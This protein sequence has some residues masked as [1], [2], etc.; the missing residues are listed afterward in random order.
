MEQ[1]FI[2]I[3]C[4]LCIL[5][6]VDLYVGVSNDAV[7][8]LNSAV[9]SRIAPFKVV[10]LVAGLGVLIGAT[11]S[12]GMMEIARSGVFNPEFFTFT[13]IM[14]IFFAVMITD[15]LLLDIFN[16]LGLPT[17]TTVSIVFE[18]L[19]GAVAA[20]AYKIS[21]VPVEQLP[22]L[23]GQVI[24]SIGDYINNEKALTIISGI[25][26]SV[27]VAFFSGS[28]VQYVMRLI[29]TFKYQNVYKYLGG[30]FGGI[31]ITAIFYF[32]VMKG[33]KGSSFM[34][35][36]YIAWINEHTF[37][38]LLYS[39]ASITLLFQLL[40]SLF[41]VN[42]F[43][44][45]ILA[46]TFALAFAF[47]GNDLVNFVGVP[48]AAIDSYSNFAAEGHNMSM[49]MGS[50]RNTVQAPTIFLLF[51]GLVM[52]LTLWFSKKAQRVVRTSINLSSSSRG[53][54]EQFGSSLMARSIV[55]GVAGTGKFM[56]QIL[57]ASVFTFLEKRM[58][59]P[60][61]KKG[62]VVLPFDQVRAAIN[63]VLSSILIASATSLKLPLSTT[64]VTFM[65]AMGSSFADGAWDRESAVYRVSGVLSVIGGWFITA[66]CAFTACAGMAYLVFVG[67]KIATIALMVVVCLILVRSNFFGKKSKDSEEETSGTKS[68]TIRTTVN[69]AIQEYFTRIISVYKKGL[70]DFQGENLRQLRSDKND[71]LAIHEEI[72]KRRGEYYRFAVEGGD[73]K[74]DVDTRHY[75]YRIFTN[76]KE[77]SHGLRGAVGIAHNHVDNNHRTFKGALADNLKL[78][79][80]DLD[81]LQ[82]FLFEY[83]SSPEID[84]AALSARTN[85]S[86][87]LL[88]KI[89]QELL[90]G[91]SANDLS[92]RGSELYLNFLQFS[93]DIVNRFA[94]IAYLQH[95]LNEEFCQL[96]NSSK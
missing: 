56:H 21:T 55:R 10:M 82:R 27:V 37:S 53:A 52:V 62:E 67:G 26:I 1:Y 30:I 20:A 87:K 28:V 86:V 89:Q 17:S 15:V 64:Y 8:F 22:L 34:K 74:I 47:A 4:F 36:E 49:L 93:R 54:K 80:D 13:E 46:G 3:L 43:P 44:F 23:N 31:A 51:A 75:Y 14:V 91:I 96:E 61:H 95:E 39:F 69:K 81:G 76:L 9:G 84:D 33:A 60:V 72:S 66:I 35:P 58:E 71:A 65:V 73:E 59:Q 2:V 63:L 24:S 90:Q 57:P 16:S 40:I 42:I 88:S 6:I 32:L 78:M 19:G 45:V 85:Q 38:I 12:S 77:I 5:A 92:L 25:L 94:L 79:V 70:D 50:L 18:L 83:V 48:L 29:F 68:E 7:N 41:R 11:F